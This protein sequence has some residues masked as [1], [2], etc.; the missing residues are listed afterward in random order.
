MLQ[1]PRSNLHQGEVI[2]AAQGPLLVIVP[3]AGDAPSQVTG[4]GSPSRSLPLLT[5]REQAAPSSVP[6]PAIPGVGG[7]GWG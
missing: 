7:G 4:R 1:L 3:G 2:G 5:A 6:Q